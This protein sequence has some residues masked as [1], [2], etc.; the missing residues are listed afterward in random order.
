MKRRSLLKG[1]LGVG[2]VAAGNYVFKN[3]LITAA[4]AQ[5]PVTPCVVVVFQRGGCDGLNTVVPYGDTGYPPLRPT[6]E[7]PAPN[8]SDPTSAIELTNPS[9]LATHRDNFFGLHPSLAPFMEIYN[10]GDMAVLPTVQYNEATRSHFDGQHRIESGAPRD[11]LDGWLN[12]H[13]SQ[14]GP[15]GQLQAVHFGGS[16][17][18]ALRGPIPVQSFS[19]INSFNLGLNGGD[20]VALT[21]AVLPVYNEMP[22]PATAYQ[23]LVHQYG[24]VLF[25]NLGVVQNIDTGSYVPTNGA[26]YPN[27][28]YG[29]RLREIAQLIKE[30]VGLEAATVDIGGWDTH[31]DQGGGDPNGRQARRFAEYSSGIQALY[32]DLGADMDNVVIISMT[33]FGRTSFENGSN[34]TDH[35]NAASWF[36]VGGGVTGGVYGDWPGLDPAN[37]LYQGR[38]LQHTIDFRD[39]LADVLVNHFGHSLTSLGALLPDHIYDTPV[40]MFNSSVQTA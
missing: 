33:E 35:G 1:L 4:Q 19:F 36:V 30:G 21:N 5:S 39:V 23:Q 27:G 17:A 6:I 31:S 34:G 22:S 14:V 12:R 15:G 28:S 9:N 10:A 26:I 29:R 20:E 11:D 2:S 37:D 13:L 8:A 3:P 32:R 25:S 38:Y 16:L 40:G 18:Q 7:I 24:Q